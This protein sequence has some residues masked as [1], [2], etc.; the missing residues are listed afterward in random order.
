MLF[1]IRHFHRQVAGHVALPGQFAA[2]F[3]FLAS[4]IVP[5]STWL[6]VFR[7]PQSVPSTSPQL[8]P[9]HPPA[10]LQRGPPTKVRWRFFLNNS[11]FAAFRLLRSLENTGV[12]GGTLG[13]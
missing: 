1:G 3:H 9:G 7:H 4:I 13:G 11:D 8:F 12:V 10:K 5:K 6:S 2:K